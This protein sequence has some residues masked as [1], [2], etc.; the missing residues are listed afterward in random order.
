MRKKTFIRVSFNLDF[1][2]GFA[3]SVMVA[4]IW[5]T[6]CVTFRSSQTW[7]FNRMHRICVPHIRPMTT[8]VDLTVAAI[9]LAAERL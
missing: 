6:K 7:R 2:A 5:V 3:G 4:C 1:D 8:G 9:A